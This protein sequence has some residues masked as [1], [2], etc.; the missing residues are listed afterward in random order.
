MYGVCF[1]EADRYS[2]FIFIKNV[3]QFEIVYAPP[4]SHKSWVVEWDAIDPLYN[5]VVRIHNDYLR[6]STLIFK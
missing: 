3:I 1:C 6:R 4:P 2:L 5:G